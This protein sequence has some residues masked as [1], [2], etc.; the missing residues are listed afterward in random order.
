MFNAVSAADYGC[1]IEIVPSMR[2]ETPP[3]LLI[4]GAILG[5]DD[6][7]LIVFCVFPLA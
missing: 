4:N 6:H 5:V 1:A 3:H 2:D 7:T